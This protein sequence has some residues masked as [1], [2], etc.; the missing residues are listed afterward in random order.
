MYRAS[1]P[2]NGSVTCQHLGNLD[3]PMIN[4]PTNRQAGGFIGKLYNNN[5][6]FPHSIHPHTFLRKKYD[7]DRK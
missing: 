4:H 6:F 1:A 5:P 2:M 7:N 3:G